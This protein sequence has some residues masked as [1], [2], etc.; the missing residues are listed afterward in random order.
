MHPPSF[1][2]DFMWDWCEWVLDRGLPE[3]PATIAVGEA[4]PIARWVG[5]FAAVLIVSC[6]VGG[7]SDEDTDEDPDA[8]PDQPIYDLDTYC[9]RRM[10]GRWEPADGISG[11][12][13]PLEASL[14]PMDLPARRAQIYSTMTTGGLGWACIAFEYTA[15]TAAS[16]VELT[17]D[18]HTTVHPVE[19]PL[20]VGVVCA[21]WL[22]QVTVRLLTETGEEIAKRTG[23]I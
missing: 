4:V 6:Y 23:V 17:I 15:G 14:S 18:G 9:F 20:S 12:N 7:Q 8:D 21:P 5:D 11:S 10:D 19:A 16:A 22:R 1:A 13:W 2:D 3:L